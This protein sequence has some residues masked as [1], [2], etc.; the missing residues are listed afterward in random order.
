MGLDGDA[1]GAPRV[2]PLEWGEICIEVETAAEKLTAWQV[3]RVNATTGTNTT[4]GSC[5]DR[6]PAHPGAKRRRQPN[7]ALHPSGVPVAE[8]VVLVPNRG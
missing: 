1:A 2:E 8:L 7:P 6:R 5:R 3:Y 4:T